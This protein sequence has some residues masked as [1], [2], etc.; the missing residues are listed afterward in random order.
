[1]LLHDWFVSKGRRESVEISVCTIEGAPMA[2]AG[3]DAAKLILPMLDERNIEYLPKR[4][5]VEIESDAIRFDDGTSS[6]YD[7]LISVPPHVPPRVVVEA[8]LAPAEGW[9]QVDSQ[10]LSVSGH[11]RLY[12]IGDVTSVRLPGEFA[13]NLP[14]F[15]PKAGVMAEAQGVTVAENI[16]A[17]IQGLQPEA[18]FD[19]K[20]FCFI[21]VGSEMAVRGDLSFFDLP[22][23][24]MS[25]M[26]PNHEDFEDKKRWIDDFVERYLG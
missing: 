22:H 19:G 8:G 17:E 11:E 7:L 14:L 13:P 20:G 24:H 2:T 23:P 1:M 18:S 4:K 25:A 3:P 12:A 6:Q 16:A 9:V 26:P 5:A 15:L 21:E 10:R